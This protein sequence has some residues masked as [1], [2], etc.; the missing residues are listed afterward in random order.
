[1]IGLFFFSLLAATSCKILLENKKYITNSGSLDSSIDSRGVK[2]IEE[3]DLSIIN[4]HI[5]R[6]E[7]LQILENPVISQNEKLNTIKKLSYLLDN[8]HDNS[9]RPPSL[10]SGLTHDF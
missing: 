4:V 2:E 6:Y 3:I 7:L 1:M 8:W 9:V 10:M 5:K